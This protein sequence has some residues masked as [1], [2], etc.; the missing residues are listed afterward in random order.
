MLF[1]LLTLAHVCVGIFACHFLLSSPLTRFSPALPICGFA[2][3]SL[4][5]EGE[6]E[7]A[8]VGVLVLLGLV[9]AP[10]LAVEGRD[11]ALLTEDDRLNV[12]P[13]DGNCEQHCWC[14]S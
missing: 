11:L 1:Y 13:L 3:V 9:A 7:R 10:P 12:G 2:E 14:Q 4:A 5:V 6:A 8:L